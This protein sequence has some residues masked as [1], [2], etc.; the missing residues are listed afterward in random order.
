MELNNSFKGSYMKDKFFKIISDNMNMKGFQYYI[1]INCDDNGLYFTD[2]NNI[3]SYLSYGNKIA[4]ISIPE[5]AHVVRMERQFK[6]DI[7]IIEKIYDL[8]DID[9][10]KMLI[11]LDVDIHAEYDYALR[12]NAK[13]GNLEIVKFL[14]DNGADVHSANGLALKFAEEEDH[15]EIVNYLQSIV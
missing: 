5:N 15:N 2:G 7:I 6:S 4:I 10:W 14:V 13:I 12:W 11:S 3:C 9:T 1:G 8:N